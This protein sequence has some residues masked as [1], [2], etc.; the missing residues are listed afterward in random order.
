MT[1]SQVR[2][3][4]KTFGVNLGKN[5]ATSLEIKVFKISV[6]GVLKMEQKMMIA[7]DRKITINF[8][9]TRP[10]GA[11]IHKKGSVTNYIK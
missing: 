4:W 8:N 10:D 5:L 6:G 3:H 7:D 1:D 9:R 11:F 2:L